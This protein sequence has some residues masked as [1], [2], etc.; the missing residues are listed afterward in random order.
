MR[1]LVMAGLSSVLLVAAAGAAGRDPGYL[2][3]ATVPVEPG[4]ATY[5]GLPEGVGLQVDMVDD[6]G[7]S[8]GLLETQDVLQELDGQTLVNHEQLAA[9]VR[10]LHKA[11]DEVKVKL[12]R[13][14]EARTVTVKLGAA[15]ERV[16]EA[17]R[18]RLPGRRDERD[19]AF[20]F[21]G[22]QG[23]AGWGALPPDMEA[24]LQDLQAQIDAMTRGWNRRSA[25]KRW[26]SAGPWGG[27]EDEQEDPPGKV[28]PRV[29][30]SVHA[31]SVVSVQEGD[32]RMTLTIEDGAKHL[33]AER[34]G[35]VLHDGPV[36]TDAQRKDLPE[37]VRA[38]L[39][40]MEQNVQVEVGGKSPQKGDVRIRLNDKDR[41]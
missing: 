21:H 38:K 36:D 2:G 41:I 14:G 30:G 6:K 12:L 20:A 1:K 8:A 32:L 23:R 39:Q 4:L 31:K 19:D 25:G 5:L 26:G 13:K 18:L 7:P 15:P 22:P 16:P 11:G 29:Q 28:E 10:S 17:P 35:K 24:Q 33:K 3:V 40:D 34:D 27:A 37:A 9:V